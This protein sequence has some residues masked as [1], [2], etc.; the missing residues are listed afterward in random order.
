MIKHKVYYY[1]EIRDD[2]IRCTRAEFK[3]Y[4][5][6]VWFHPELEDESEIAEMI[7]QKTGLNKSAGYEAWN[8]TFEPVENDQ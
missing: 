7:L 4:L 2:T 1:H 3:H 6:E 8:V 5:G